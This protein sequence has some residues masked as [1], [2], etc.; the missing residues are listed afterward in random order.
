MHW[1]A[2]YGRIMYTSEHVR[3]FSWYVSSAGPGSRLPSEHGLRVQYQTDTRRIRSQY[4][5]DIIPDNE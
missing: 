4:L 2:H 1:P 3:A 5:T